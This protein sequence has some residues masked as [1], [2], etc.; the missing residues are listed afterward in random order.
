[1]D[2]TLID[3][4]QMWKELGFYVLRRHNVQP[5]P[6]LAEKLKPMGLRDGVTFCKEYCGLP[7]TV[8]ELISEA[9]ER[10]EDFYCNEVQAKPGVKEALSLLK[11]EGV[12][13]YIATAT[14]RALAETAL[15]HAGFRTIFAASSPAGRP[16]STN[17]TAPPSTNAP[18]P[19]SVPPRRTRSCLKTPFTPSGRQR[20][21]DS[22]S[23]RFTT[24]PPR[25][26][27]RKSAGWPI[28]ITVPLRSCIKPKL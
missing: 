20:L 28:T 17:K 7:G 23:P 16:D 13:M 9:Q 25:T 14:D 1:M 11:M 2:G 21:P 27:R 3:S 6:D 8:D 12:W 22:G 24:P 5:P 26:T 10:V 18:S 4:M 19:A 15:R